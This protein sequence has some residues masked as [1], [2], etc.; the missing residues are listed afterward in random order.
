[1]E[2]PSRQLTG[3]DLGR[4]IGLGNLLPGD[5][6]IYSGVPFLSATVGAA[7]EAANRYKS[8]Q[9]IGAA[10]ALLPA[11]IGNPLKAYGAYPNEG[12]RQQ[13]GQ[14]VFA[15]SEV[16]PGMKAVR[17]L[18][19]TPTPIARRQQAMAD[20]AAIKYATD[21]ASKNLLA[22]IA[23]EYALADDAQTHGDTAGAAS[24]SAAAEGFIQA[25]A[26]RLANADVPDWQQIPTPR[27]TQ[28]RKTIARYLF[29]MQGSTARNQRMKQEELAA[30]PYLSQ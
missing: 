2:G 28:I 12:V 4:R 17:A 21:E 3:M 1:M 10:A 9:P 25:N 7:M 26:E 19:A 6:D 20:Q 18:G 27:A 8:G 15:P 13:Q 24:H 16:T 14:M 30:S 23:G 29:P 5:T 11:G 22:R